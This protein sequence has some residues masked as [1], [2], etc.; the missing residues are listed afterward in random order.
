MAQNN[1]I[2]YMTSVGKSDLC[3]INPIEVCLNNYLK[4]IY[5]QVQILL[6]CFGFFSSVV[7]TKAKKE[8]GEQDLLAAF[9]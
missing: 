5:D 4:K 3:W 7:C 6:G 1:I 9:G 2:F 8:L